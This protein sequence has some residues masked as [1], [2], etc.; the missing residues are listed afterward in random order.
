VNRLKI[1]RLESRR[2][3]RDIYEVVACLMPYRLCAWTSAQLKLSSVRF[4]QQLSTR[5]YIGLDF[6][7]DSFL[8]FRQFHSSYVRLLLSSCFA[9]RGYSAV[10]RQKCKSTIGCATHTRAH[11]QIIASFPWTPARR[12]AYSHLQSIHRDVRVGL[13][14]Y[15]WLLA[16]D[17][18]ILV[19][20]VC[21]YTSTV[22]T[23]AVSLYE[24][25][26]AIESLL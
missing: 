26:L 11:A 5:A 18:P 6:P 12:A 2:K 8:L 3:T 23:I 1:Q 25:P 20:T 22:H 7:I 9:L 10:H 14:N 15:I 21:C 17:G 19:F 24:S 4:M 16:R 13:W